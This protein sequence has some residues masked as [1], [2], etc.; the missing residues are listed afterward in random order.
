[1]PIDVRRSPEL[2]AAWLG[3]R[4]AKRE[5]QRDINRDV[6]QQV[7]PVWR[8]ELARRASTPLERAVLVPGGRVAVGARN[9]SAIAA[10]SSRG[11]SGGLVPRTQYA[12][13]EW[14]SDTHNQF[15]R[16]VWPAGYVAGPA[17]AAL[18][19]KTIGTW[20]R[21]IVDHFR[22]VGEVTDS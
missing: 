17:A 4:L 2:Q 5:I 10:G 22:A 9:V 21:T 7:N 8:A 15:R 3:A 16:R 19:S 11:P 18:I 14:G 6:K 13:A 12:G 20:V 1:M